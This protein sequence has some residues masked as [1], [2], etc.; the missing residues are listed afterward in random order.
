[1]K[2]IWIKISKEEKSMAGKL[3]TYHGDRNKCHKLL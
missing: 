1:L 2:A 3:I